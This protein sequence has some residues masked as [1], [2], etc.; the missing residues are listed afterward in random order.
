MCFLPGRGLLVLLNKR[1]T[2]AS[3]WSMEGP[4]RVSPRSGSSAVRGNLLL[5][6]RWGEVPVRHVFLLQLSLAFSFTGA[7]SVSYNFTVINPG[8]PWCEFEGQVNGQTFLRYTCSQK[9]K[10]DF[11]NLSMRN[12]TE[13]CKGEEETL[14]DLM[15]NF[16]MTPSQIKPKNSTTSGKFEW[17]R[18]EV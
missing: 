4:G 10:C 12:I 1:G 16:K 18:A 9:A 15:E 2:L 3:H 7:F 8:F 14:K 5:S 13:P 6:Q 17:P 11:H